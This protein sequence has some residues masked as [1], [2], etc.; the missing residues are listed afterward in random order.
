MPAVQR[1]GDA[2]SKGGIITTG[3]GSV[4]VNGRPIAVAGSAVTPH[5]PCSKKAPQHC[6]AKTSGGAGSVRVN[7]RPVLLTGNKDTCG[8]A[9]AGGSPD[10]K[11]V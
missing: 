3:I 9:R 1:Q 7:G 10:V 11:A 6:K 2:N 8:D 4:R 5:P